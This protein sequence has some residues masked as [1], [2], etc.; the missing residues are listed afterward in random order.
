[1]IAPFVD[2]S[3]LA[4]HRSVVAVAD[5]RWY[6]DGHSGRAAFEAGHVPGAVFVELGEVLAGPPSDSE[7]RHP[8][9]SPERF[10][11]GLGRLGIGADHTVVAY[12][13]AGGVIASRLVWMLRILGQPAA[14]LEGGLSSWD[15]PL[16]SGPPASR[17]EVRVNPRDWPAERLA[18]IEEVAGTD[19][20]LIDAR[21]P[22]RFAGG[23]DP[24]DP[25]SGHIPGARSLPAAGNLRPDGRLRARE[26]LRERFAQAGIGEGSRVISYCG[27]GVSACHNLLVLEHVGL[28]PGRLYPGSW[29]Q[30]SRDPRRPVQT[31]QGPDAARR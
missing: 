29:S 8:L 28:A 3:W 2:A 13:D 22:A 12:D 30:W 10:A 19:A 11:A 18:A 17:P 4:Q 31:G 27:S 25:R 24:V 14:V 15:E 16:E 5:V 23:P 1:M 20:V 26:E 6:L 21:D 7:G 9:P